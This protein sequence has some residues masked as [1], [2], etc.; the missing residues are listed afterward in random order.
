MECAE[1]L[2]KVREKVEVEEEE[3]MKNAKLDPLK[4]IPL[5]YRPIFYHQDGDA[6]V[7]PAAV[8]KPLATTWQLEL[9]ALLM[10]KAMGAY[11]MVL[12]R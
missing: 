12:D 7:L 1:V 8:R 10:V 11:M 9:T 4:P 2:Q 5:E 3:Q 6:R